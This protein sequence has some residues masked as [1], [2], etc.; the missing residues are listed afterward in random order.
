MKIK[1]EDWKIPPEAEAEDAKL[2]NKYK[3][4]GNVR[5]AVKA[6]KSV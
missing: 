4:Y 2:Y 1:V 3:N 6:H 5:L